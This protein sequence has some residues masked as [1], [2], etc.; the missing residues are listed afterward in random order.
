MILLFVTDEMSYDSFHVDNEQI[1]LVGVER[2]FGGD[3][4]ESTI[5]Q[6]PLGRT[7]FEEVAGITSYVTIT[8]PNPARISLDG[9]DFRTGYTAI[10]SSPDFFSLFSFPLASGSPDD[11]LKNPG[12]VVISDEIARQFF[13]NEDPIGKTLTIDR[14]GVEEYIVTGVT[15]K[16]RKNTYL[17]FDVVFSIQGLSSTKSNVDSWGSSMYNTFVKIDDGGSVADQETITN[18]VIDTY[19]GETWAPNVNYFFVP[20]TDLYLS[21]LV[22][23]EGFKGNYTYIFIFSSIAL[24]ILVLANINYINL[25]TAKGMQRAREIGVR[26]VLGANK[27]QLVKQFL[28]ESLILSF[29]SLGLALILSELILPGFNHFFDKSLTL[30]IFENFNFLVLLLLITIIV[31]ALTGLYPAMFL[32]SFN[33]SAVLKGNSVNKI[34]GVSLRKVLVVFQFGISSLLIV[35]TLVVLGQMNFL[36]TKDLGFNKENALFIAVDEVND[37]DAFIGEIQNHQ[38]V[39]ATSYSNG[40]PGRFYFSTSNKFNP[41]MPDEEIS[42]HVIST[43]EAFAQ[44]MELEILA[45]RYF[46]EARS[47]DHQDAI[48]INQAMQ[49]SM[50]WVDAN[51]AVGQTLSNDSRIIGVIKDFNFQSLRTAITPVIISSIQKQ[52]DTFSGGEVLVVRYDENQL[53]DLLPY[54]HDVWETTGATAA[55]DYGFLDDQ[56]DRL[57]ETDKK[58]GTVFTFFALIGILVSCMGLLGLTFFSAELRTKEIGIRKVLGASVANIVTLFSFDF[59]K[60]VLIGFVIAIPFSWYAMN[61][62]LNSFAYRIE[63]GIGVFLMT[64]LTAFLISTIATSWQ[65]IKAAT[66]DP[67]DSLKNE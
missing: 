5:T 24:L 67:V 65:S 56:M 11:V 50:G 16:P 19:L 20:I 15:D 39:Q 58:L 28:G 55:L 18:Q 6:F 27:M 12:T 41:L 30:N 49:R 53:S 40:I 52:N 26:K 61:T 9:I 23:A 46:E 37:K 66:A 29:L 51:E 34:G 32:S 8:P 22:T 43:D 44:T 25:S 7:S 17:D 62:W 60:L 57:Y 21:D 31:G 4:R 13:P 35:C 54:L 47:D 1:H 33:T 42:A 45:G 36:M 63:I 2:K 14:Y 48:V 64:G 59:L 38:A 3:F 10:A